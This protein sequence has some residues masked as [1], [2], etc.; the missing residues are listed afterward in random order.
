M[1]H[2]ARAAIINVRNR[3]LYD[4]LSR[5]HLLSPSQH[6]FRPH[7]STET[8]LI[9]V[10]DQIL[11]ATDKG[12]ITLLCLLDLSKCFDVIDHSKLLEKLE[13]HGVD[14]EWFRSYL[15]NHTQS[16]SITDHSGRRQL[17]KPLPNSVGVFQ[18]SS[19]GP[20]LYSVFSNDLSY[21]APEA[22]VV[23]YADDTQILVS[24]KKGDLG[25]VIECM[26]R[27]LSSLDTWFLANS[28]KVNA[29]KTQLMMFGSGPNLRSLPQV[30]VC[31]RGETLGTELSVRNLGVL[32]D[33][34]LTWDAHVAHL[35]RKCFGLLIG[36]SHIR[37]YLPQNILATLVHGLVISHVRYC[38]SVFGNCS[39][40][41]HKQ[42]QKI[43][44]FSARVVSGRRKFDHISDVLRGPGWLTS[45]QLSDYH[46]A[47][48]ANCI[49]QRGEP[50]SLSAYF[51][52]NSTVRSR[53]TRQDEQ[54]HL[55]RFRIGAGSRRFAYRAPQLLNSLPPDLLRLKPAAFKKALKKHVKG[56]T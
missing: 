29:S 12:E 10:S 11:S 5:N 6:G 34:V 30:E 42:L 51:Q 48:L 17:S 3:Q 19:L 4:Y 52:K 22:Q 32:F 20:L 28:L 53:Q 35:T 21:A 1:R 13:L 43:I 46:C 8:A 24:G 31:F 37:H 18:G 2:A 25:R 55:P 45:K 44:N 7:H 15:S 54:F 56:P 27:T 47:S 50:A 39:V 40:T 49:N 33:P 41:N 38:I 36:L 16:V 9:H 23:Q 14:A 26:E